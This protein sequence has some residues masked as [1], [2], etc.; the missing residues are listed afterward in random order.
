MQDI[1]PFFKWRDQYMAEED[2]LSPFFKRQYSEFEFT[3]TIYNFYIHPQWDDFESSTLYLKILFVDYTEQF[4][5][6]EFIG[7][8]NDAIQNDI[9]YLKRNVI[10][11]L[12]RQDI[13]YFILILDNVYNFHSSD[14]CY[15]EEWL[16]DLNEE[17]GWIVMLGVM[18]HLEEEM[19]SVGL[20]Y[21]V[22]F[23]SHFNAIEWRR[24]DPVV[25]FSFVEKALQRQTRRLR[26]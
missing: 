23:G 13:K 24:L 5:I 25:L 16:D 2:P 4:A 19:V 1:E 12:I 15:Y 26:N 10:E 21:Y 11:K 22:H 8:W 6:I 20:Q 7:E 3:N 18:E 17:G 14:D 9:M